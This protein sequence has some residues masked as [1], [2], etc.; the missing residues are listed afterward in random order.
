MRQ[1]L[2]KRGVPTLGHNKAELR[3]KLDRLLSGVR[4]PIALLANDD[5]ELILNLLSEYAIAQL[6]PLHDLKTTI[7][8]YT[9]GSLKSYM[10]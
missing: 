5:I 4:R 7:C 8:T 6:E 1:E 9:S 3:E 10:S 2:T